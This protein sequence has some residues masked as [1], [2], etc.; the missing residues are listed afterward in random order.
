[1]SEE[2]FSAEKLEYERI[3]SFQTGWVAGTVVVLII[4]MAAAWLLP[5][6]FNGWTVGAATILTWVVFLGPMES[7]QDHLN[8]RSRY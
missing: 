2:K 4:S 1:M 6:V 7:S 5:V 8:E 3:E